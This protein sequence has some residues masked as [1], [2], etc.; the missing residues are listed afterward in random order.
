ML[1]KKCPR[2]RKRIRKDF[3]Y[4]PFCGRS[5]RELD[6]MDIE[7][8]ER[9]FGFL[10][11][12][13]R[14]DFPEKIGIRM[15][16]G[17][18]RLFNSL[19]R[20]LDKQMRALDRE[21]GEEVKKI[22]REDKI[23]KTKFAPGITTSGISISINATGDK[24][25]VIKVKKFGT[26]GPTIKMERIGKEIKEKKLKKPKKL[27]K[28]EERRIAKLP[29]KEAKTNVRRL[30]NRVIYEIDLPGVRSINDVLINK[31]E[32][33]IEIKA[34]AKNKVFVKLI[35]IDLPLINYSLKNG[36]LILELGPID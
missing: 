34:V 5:F 14:I 15:P 21:I 27:T 17:F 2:C 3:D 19:M 29:R 30:S 11:K 23:K 25:P 20:E 36:K 32:N 8:L 13:D 35:P 12:D 16:V 1:S 9:D 33:S 4:C 26:G 22:R 18:G 10:G 31:L 6:E 24:P 7:K 28:A